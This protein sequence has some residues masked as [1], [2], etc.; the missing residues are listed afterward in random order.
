MAKKR[1]PRR[2][3]AMDFET[4][5]SMDHIVEIGCV[6]IVDGHLTGRV[7]HQLV[8]PLVPI[9]SMIAAIHGITSADV[10]RKPTFATIADKL[11]GFVDGAPII[12]HAEYVER[13]ILT[14]EMTRLGRPA[15]DPAGFICTLKMARRSGRFTRNGLRDVCLDLGIVV[16][17]T[18]D[19]FHD[20]LVDA[21]MAAL[22]YLS[23]VG[24]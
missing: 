2:F 6:E 23:L 5:V 18:R 12:S 1:V 21:Q 19:G 14:K 16:R 13:N 7:F 24:G 22:V 4:A 20:A 17:P 11:L 8:R 3:V 15:P 10:A 9:E